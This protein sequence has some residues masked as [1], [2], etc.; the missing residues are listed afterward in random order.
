MFKKVLI[1]FL[2]ISFAVKAQYSVIGTIEPDSNYSWIL[3]YKLENGKQVYIENANVVNGKFQFNLSSTQPVGI[4]RAYYQIENNSYVEFIYNNESINF[5][6]NPEKPTETIKFSTSEENMIYQEYYENIFFLQKTID[7]LQLAYFKSENDKIDKKLEA[8]YQ[9]TLTELKKT[10]SDF[11]IKSETKLAHNFIIASAQYNA[12]VP[13]K[14]PT[15]Y[16]KAVKTHFFDHVNF[17]NTVLSNATF[18]NDRITDYV[19]YLNQS[20]NKEKRNIFQKRAIDEVSKKLNNNYTAIKN[21]DETLLH[22]YVDEDNFEMVDFVLNNHYNNL[23]GEYQDFALKFEIDTAMK[24]AVG[25]EAPNLN[26]EENGVQKNLHSLIGADYYVVVFFSSGCTHCQREMP[27]FH[28]FISTLINVSVI[29]VGLEDEK[30]PWDKMTSDFKNFTNIIDLD[31]WES[32]KVIDYGITA[33]PS[34]FILDANKKI[35]AKPYDVE[36]LKQMFEEK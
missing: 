5:T 17:S 20:E 12:E 1:V 9:E 28:D 21:F 36:E 29:A 11:E 7:S 34:Y 32:K 10:Q 19:F 4:Y 35:I 27:V 8:N 2:L 15:D 22:Q 3:L 25:K 26:W 6:F 14:N 31:K 13:F 18:L 16:V 33:I 24:T 30:A 23:P